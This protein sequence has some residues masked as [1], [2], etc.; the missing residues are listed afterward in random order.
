MDERP[1]DNENWQQNFGFQKTFWTGESTGSEQEKK[2][3]KKKNCTFPVQ[4]VCVCGGGGSVGAGHSRF[5][6]REKVRPLLPRETDRLCPSGQEEWKT[7]KTRK[8][9]RRL[10]RK[11][12][13]LPW[14][15]VEASH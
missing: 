7:G 14:N 6:S 4:S 10:E 9:K 12:A 8:G 2:A 11:G 13:S 1:R 15:L 3:N 5:K